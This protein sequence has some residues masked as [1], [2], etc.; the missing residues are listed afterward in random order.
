MGQT[1]PRRGHKRSK[2]ET[3]DGERPEVTVVRDRSR[4][5][6]EIRETHS[7]LST[8]SKTEIL[9]KIVRDFPGD[10]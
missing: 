3:P 9:F 10:I 5:G 8:P 2:E 4:T 7:Y 1:L 6:T